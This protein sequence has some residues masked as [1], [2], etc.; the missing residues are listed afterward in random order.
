MKLK[1]NSISI[2]IFKKHIGSRTQDILPNRQ[3]ETDSLIIHAE[4]QTA[5]VEIGNKIQVKC[6]V[7][8]YR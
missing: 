5:R 1:F 2:K 4:L 3:L 6:V 7:S 8:L